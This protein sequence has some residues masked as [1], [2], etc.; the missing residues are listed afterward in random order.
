MYME[1][2]NIRG[3]VVYESQQVK[4]AQDTSVEALIS[5]VIST[6]Y[7]KAVEMNLTRSSCSNLSPD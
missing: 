7:F 2:K 4:R 3:T 1:M 6:E 5:C